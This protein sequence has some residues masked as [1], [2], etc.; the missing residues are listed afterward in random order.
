MR[1]LL[2]CYPWTYT[3]KHPCL[4][5][6]EINELYCRPNVLH[7]K[8]FG[9]QDIFYFSLC[10]I[11]KIWEIICGW[12]PSLDVWFIYSSPTP[13][14]QNVNV[15][16]EPFC[17]LQVGKFHTVKS[18]FLMPHHWEMFWCRKSLH[19]RREM[20]SQYNGRWFISL[21]S[22][23]PVSNRLMQGVSSWSSK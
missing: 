1:N 3:E 6:D 19:F 14:T 8:S 13:Y 17:S 7:L 18:E 5:R 12:N 2:N 21:L 4:F 15:N 23:C 11:L 16:F 10:N 22:T 20:Y 9:V